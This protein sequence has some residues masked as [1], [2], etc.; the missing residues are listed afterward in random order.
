MNGNADAA[1]AT[2]DA[3]QEFDTAYG[4]YLKAIIAA[5]GGKADGVMNNL[6]TAI[7][8]DASL[9][10]KAKDDAEFIKMFDNADFKALTN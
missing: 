7:G 1:N 2:L 8:K 9:K 4:N 3:S 5:R 10:A 6:K